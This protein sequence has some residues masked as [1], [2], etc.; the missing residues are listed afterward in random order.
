MHKPV[1]PGVLQRC[2]LELL[3]A[4]EKPSERFH[5]QIV[6]YTIMETSALSA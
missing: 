5:T 1:R 3:A 2:M 6:I 4:G